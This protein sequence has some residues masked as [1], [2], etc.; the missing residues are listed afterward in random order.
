MPTFAHNMF[1]ADLL[2][3]ERSDCAPDWECTYILY[4]PKINKQTKQKPHR[5]HPPP[6]PDHISQ[7]I[8]YLTLIFV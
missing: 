7:K 8:V 5:H 6:V 4:L 1:I 3:A 2:S